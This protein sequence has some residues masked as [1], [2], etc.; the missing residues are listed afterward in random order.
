MSVVGFYYV[1]YIE[2]GDFVNLC[3]FVCVYG[4]ICFGCDF[5]WFVVVLFDM[6]CVV[7]F[8]VVGCG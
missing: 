1:V 7:C 3:V 6:Y 5:D 2:W 4:L 8:D